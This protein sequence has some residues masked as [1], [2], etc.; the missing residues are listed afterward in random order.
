VGSSSS[1]GLGLSCNESPFA[2]G[3][4]SSVRLGLLVPSPTGSAVDPSANFTAPATEP[5]APPRAAPTATPTGPPTAPRVAPA[6]APVAAPPPTSLKTSSSIFSV[7]LF[8]RRSGSILRISSTAAFATLAPPQ[9]REHA[10]LG[11]ALHTF[12]AHLMIFAWHATAAT[13]ALHGRILSATARIDVYLSKISTT[14]SSSAALCFA[15]C[16]ASSSVK[17]AAGAASPAKRATSFFLSSGVMQSSTA[18]WRIL[19]SSS[20]PASRSMWYPGTW[21]KSP[22]SH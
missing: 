15:I 18:C 19:R 4:V 22:T 1:L 6:A 7:A 2:D 9:A 12:L 20:K 17:A 8:V 21:T 14:R 11:V 16:M 13:A 3:S 5:A 10:L